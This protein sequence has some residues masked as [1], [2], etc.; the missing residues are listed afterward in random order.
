MHRN[1]ISKVISTITA[2]ITRI[3]LH[4]MGGMMYIVYNVMIVMMYMVNRVMNAIM[5]NWMVY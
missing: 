1:C 2:M 4:H 5:M 3:M